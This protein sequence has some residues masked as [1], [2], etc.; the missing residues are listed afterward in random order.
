MDQDAAGRCLSSKSC[1]ILIKINI[2]SSAFLNLSV[3]EEMSLNG[4]SGNCSAY[5]VYPVRN[6]SCMSLF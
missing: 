4:E 1:S 2:F 6:N 5:F 3:M